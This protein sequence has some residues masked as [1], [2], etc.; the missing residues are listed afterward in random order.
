[1]KG[2]AKKV[3]ICG[4][5]I[6]LGDEMVVEYTG[7]G[8]MSGGR[9]S[10]KVVELWSPELNKGHLQARLACGWCFHNRDKIISHIT[11]RE[12]MRLEGLRLSRPIW[13]RDLTETKTK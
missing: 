6:R 10:G 1:M 8:S 7:T 5:T 2:L 11:A 9:I 13:S 4:K 12:A 3:T